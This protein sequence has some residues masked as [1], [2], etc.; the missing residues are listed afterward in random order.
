ML[1]KFLPSD[2]E[3]HLLESKNVHVLTFAEHGFA[4]LTVYGEQAFGLDLGTLRKFAEE[5]NSQNETGTLVPKAPLSAVPRHLIR[6]PAK[7]QSEARAN[8]EAAIRQFLDANRKHAHLSAQRVLFDF[9]QTATDFL[10]EYVTQAIT[11]ALDDEEAL[12]EDKQVIT[13]ALIVGSK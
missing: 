6:E 12:E 7:S 3:V 4:M 8:L 1:R 10:A 11:K 2:S 5:V 13:E 9:R